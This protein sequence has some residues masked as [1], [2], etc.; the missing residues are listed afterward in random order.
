MTLADA[1]AKAAAEAKAAREAKAAADAKAA[2]AAK[3]AAD[4]KAAAEAS[5]RSSASSASDDE[6][7]EP[8]TEELVLCAEMLDKLAQ[9]RDARPFAKPMEELWSEEVM[10][11]YRTVIKRPMDLR[12][13][14]EKTRRGE[15]NDGGPEAFAKDV[16]LVWRNCITYIVRHLLSACRVM[17]QL[18][19][20]IQRSFTQPF[21]SLR[22]VCLFRLVAVDLLAAE[23]SEVLGA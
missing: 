2:A 10:K 17:P 6:D 12:T 4:A 15:Y 1:D 13:V 20:V 23:G 8:P 18:T 9:R 14:L 21:G 19:H 5:A 22:S 16:R 3:A 7:T 11:D